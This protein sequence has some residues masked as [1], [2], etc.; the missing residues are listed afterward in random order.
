MER[1]GVPEQPVQQLQTLLKRIETLIAEL[2]ERHEADTGGTLWQRIHARSSDFARQYDDIE[3]LLADDVESNDL[4]ALLPQIESDLD[5]L[6]EEINSHS[7]HE[8][9]YLPHQ[10]LADLRNVMLII[11]RRLDSGS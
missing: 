4:V 9:Y 7:D 11:M 3:D 1:I 6:Q 2:D 10:A 5:A 8:R